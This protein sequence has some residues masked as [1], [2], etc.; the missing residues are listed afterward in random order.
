MILAILILAV[1][2]VLGT[3]YGLWSTI[4]G[5]NALSKEHW[6]WVGH[7]IRDYHTLPE[8]LTWSLYGIGGGLVLAIVLALAVGSRVKA[9]TIHGEHDKETLHGSARWGTW[10]D[11]KRAG[12]TGSKGVVVGGFPKG[13]KT[14]PLRHDGP[15]HVFCFAPTRSG[16]GVSLVI[17]TLL[18]W[19]QSV[20][21]LDIKGENY[22]LT[23]GYRASLGHKVLRF[24]PSATSG[25]VCF[26]PL[27]EIRLGTGREVADAQNISMMVIDPEAKGLRDFFMKNGWGWLNACLLHTMYRV[28]MTEERVASLKDLY[29][30]MCSA[31][32]VSFDDDGNPEVDES[33]VKKL[34]IG[35]INFDHQFKGK[36]QPAINDA[37][38]FEA[39]E[40]LRRL[41][42]AGPEFSGVF[43]SAMTELK[44]Y[45]DPILSKNISSSDFTIADLMNG[46]DPVA[47]YFVIP[48]SDIAR[49]RPI[50]RTVMNLLLTRQTEAMAFGGPA[51][52]KHRLLLMLDEFT[53]I[54]RLEIFEQAL[55]FMAGY[56]LKAFLIVQDLNQLQKAYGREHS[57]TAN[58]HVRIAYAPNTHETAKVLSEMLGKTTVV[59]QKRGTS[60]K[61]LEL[62]ASKSDSLNE[63]AR[64]LLTPDECMSLPGL[65]IKGKKVIP[66]DMLILVAGNAP[67]YGRQQLYFQDK[68]L[69]CRSEMPVPTVRQEAA[70]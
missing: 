56:G 34:I 18:E 25:S 65:R 2:V 21:V 51:L 3:A 20:F 40:M 4:W 44:L 7:F 62:F 10:S 66:G 12:L 26:N 22:A 47:L 45:A 58:C 68:E 15:E 61:G 39:Q 55:A 53:S 69:R 60:R 17:P 46:E 11:A 33:G 23:A 63:V 48:P 59:Q 42:T 35:M 29:A 28:H 70:E 41:L 5:F 67:I 6:V 13:R 19:E 36:S 14:V 64:P 50:I 37:I 32:V 9:R 38:R 16:K 57:I 27:A 24:E 31:G 30:F 1:L 43:S 49:L 8:F 54:G 52:Y